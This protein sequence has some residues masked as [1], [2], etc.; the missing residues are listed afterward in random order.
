ME[1]VS[2]ETLGYIINFL[3]FFYKRI[4]FIYIRKTIIKLFKHTIIKRFYY[5]TLFFNL[6][7]LRFECLEIKFSG[8]FIGK[9]APTDRQTDRHTYF[10]DET[11][12][13]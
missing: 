3:R 7:F 10:M 8:V 6:F 12:E 5:F 13:F 9:D 2:I 1:N 11:F 4:V